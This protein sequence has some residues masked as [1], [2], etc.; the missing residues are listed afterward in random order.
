MSLGSDIEKLQKTLYDYAMQKQAQRPGQG[1]GALSNNE[2][3]DSPGSCKDEDATAGFGAEVAH[4]LAEA[5]ITPDNPERVMQI[6]SQVG[7][8]P[9]ELGDPKALAEMA[10]E[11]TSGMSPE[12]KASFADMAR[13]VVA[14]MGTSALPPELEE[15]IKRWK[16]K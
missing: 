1:E 9:L 3:K 12:M 15:L 6:I 16:G 14:N 8:S 10:E 7:L 13:V 2:G 5:G 4:I 11:L